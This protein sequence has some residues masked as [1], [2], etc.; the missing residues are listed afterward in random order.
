MLQRALD[1]GVPAAWATAGGFYGGD[2]MLRREL[3]GRRLGYVLA[4][5]KSHRVNVGGLHGVAPSDSI[6]ASLSKRAWSRY[7]AGDGAKGRGEYDW[8]RVETCFR[9]TKTVV[10]LDRHQV[11]R[12]DCWHRYTTVIMLAAAILTATEHRR[13]AQPGLIP[14]TVIEIRRLFAKLISP[15]IHRPA[16]S[17][18]GPDGEAST[19]PG[20]A[21]ATTDTTAT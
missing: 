4:V 11:R 10:G 8:T 16:S 20:L 13:P 21:P 1:A 5:A 2:R 6:A 19:K 15:T 18:P 3:Q 7:S 12:Q 14:L 17:S 9:N